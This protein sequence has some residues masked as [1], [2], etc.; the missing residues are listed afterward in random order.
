MGAIVGIVL[1]M[2]DQIILLVRERKPAGVN[3]A[4][5]LSGRV[6]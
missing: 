6:V 4:N 1:G 3:P 5:A 2:A